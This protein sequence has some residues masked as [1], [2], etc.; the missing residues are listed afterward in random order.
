MSSK[1]AAFIGLGNMGYPM[2]GHLQGA[3]YDVT[4]YNRTASKAEAWAKEH[5]GTA[6][7]TPAKAAAEADIVCCC[8]GN[9]NDL[10]SV[11]FG[12]DGALAGMSDGSLLIDHTT[13]SATVARE[14]S[15]AAA[16][17][18][19]GFL[20]GPVSGGQEGAQKGILTVM[21]GGSDSDFARGEP[22]MQS[23]GKSVL[24]MGPVGS[25]QLTKMV[26]QMCCAN[27]IQA[28][29]E[30]MN[31]AL[32]AGLDA[33]QVVEVISK[34]AAQSWQMENR[35][36]T[37]IDGKFDF[38][39]AVDW[40]RK[41]LDLCLDEASA[42]GAQ[43]PLTALVETFYARLQAQGEGRSDNTALMRLLTNP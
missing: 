42:N 31:F 38:G 36:P 30:G 39:F 3:G 41:D 5:G 43:V 1:Q 25:G 15:E 28:L 14:I 12:D 19:I 32:K 37:M 29:A 11:I 20:D 4:V 18:G 21:V 40:M 26:N 23:Y 34:G 33:K 10:R 9:D 7:D 24:L 8:V 17:K 13:A 35:G 22:V 2:A 27:A 6:A 16:G